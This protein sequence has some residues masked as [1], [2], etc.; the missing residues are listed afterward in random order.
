MLA[1]LL[2]WSFVI[3]FLLPSKGQHVNFI[4][5]MYCPLWLEALVKYCSTRYV[6]DDLVQHTSSINQ[7][8][9][10]ISSKLPALSVPSGSNNLCMNCLFPKIILFS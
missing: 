3:D 9:N 10:C 7:Y 6:V 5:E 4:F 1:C 2:A 8:I